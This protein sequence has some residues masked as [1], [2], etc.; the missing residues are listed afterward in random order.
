MNADQL[1]A[2][3]R[4]DELAAIS[5]PATSHEL[6]G[7]IGGIRYWVISVLGEQ[8]ACAQQCARERKNDVPL[9]AE[10]AVVLEQ[11]P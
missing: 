7:A 4:I 8:S 11:T 10:L 3:Q 9:T 1:R 6:A 5:I 2:L